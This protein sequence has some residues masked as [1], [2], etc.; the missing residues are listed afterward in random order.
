MRFIVEFPG[1]QIFP[2]ESMNQLISNG[3]SV[4]S[5]PD[6]DAFI[7]PGTGILSEAGLERFVDAALQEKTSPGS[8]VFK[9]IR[10]TLDGN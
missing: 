9:K 5:I 7:F 6:P 4:Y 2:A 3:A 1:Q 8:E 10:G